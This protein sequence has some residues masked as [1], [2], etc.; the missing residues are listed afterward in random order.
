MESLQHA[1][2]PARSTLL[3]LPLEILGNIYRQ[4][5]GLRD[6]GNMR[7]TCSRLVHQ[8]MRQDTQAYLYQ[9]TP[10]AF[11]LHGSEESQAA[12]T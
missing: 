1:V 11:V 3:D 6:I 9:Q 7:L 8:S 4:L 12:K 5:D 10:V 2:S